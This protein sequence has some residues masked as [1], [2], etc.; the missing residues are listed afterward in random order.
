MRY[1]IELKSD[2]EHSL[3][4]NMAYLAKEKYEDNAKLLR[5]EAAK[6]ISTPA[7]VHHYN[8]LAEI[9]E[10]QAIEAAAII[11]LI[12]EAEER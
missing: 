1:L 6:P 12:D 2:K 5:E 4:S 10:Q 11:E 9:F 7:Q 3:L 8:Q